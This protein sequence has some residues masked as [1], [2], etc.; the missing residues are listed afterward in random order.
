MTEK[1]NR[2]FPEK[3]LEVQSFIHPENSFV[4]E[5]HSSQ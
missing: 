4:A 2:R 1:G 5:K 3:L